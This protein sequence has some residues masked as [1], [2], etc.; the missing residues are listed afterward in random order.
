MASFFL[1]I[2]DVF[3]ISL[4]REGRGSSKFSSII[5]N[6]ISFVKDY[7]L[8]LHSFNYCTKK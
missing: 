1:V 4:T 2:K 5:I 7:K 8:D 3:H 6:M